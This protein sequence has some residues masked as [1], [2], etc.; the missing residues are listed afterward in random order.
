[1]KS[2][3]AIL[4]IVMSFLVQKV[5]SQPDN[6]LVVPDTKGTY[7]SFFYLADSVI[8]SEIASFNVA[9]PIYGRKPTDSLTVLALNSYKTDVVEFTDQENINV[10]I[11]T[12]YFNPAAHRLEYFMQ[13]GFLYRID[14]RFFW[15]IDGKV[16]LKRI[17]NIQADINGSKITIPQVAYIDIFEPNL[18]ARQSLF[19]RI[20]CGV[21]VYASN[22]GERVYIYMRNGKIPCLYEV[23]WIFSNGRYMGRVVDYAY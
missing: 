9:G 7:E 19:G 5:I 18:C 3:V 4:L 21:A 13:S 15:G 11:R 14:G 1:M 23:T 16:P 22:D 20:H 2:F 8:A 6:T 17:L 12:G 10:L